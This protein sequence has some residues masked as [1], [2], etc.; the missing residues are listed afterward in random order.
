LYGFL[1]EDDEKKNEKVQLG[2]STYLLTVSH[3]TTCEKKE[4]EEE[5]KK[6]K[7]EEEKN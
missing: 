3:F 5:K 2:F 6:R 7:E 4:K 1:L